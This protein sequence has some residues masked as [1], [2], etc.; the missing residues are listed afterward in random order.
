MTIWPSKTWG[1]NMGQLGID[2]A[3]DGL[4]AG[5]NMVPRTDGTIEDLSGNGN[6]GTINGPVFE[7]SEIGPGMKVKTAG[8]KITSA[9]NGAPSV[10]S[11][12]GWAK[13]LSTGSLGSGRIFDKGTNHLSLYTSGAVALTL[14]YNNGA[15]QNEV[16]NDSYTQNT[17]FFFAITYD[18]AYLKAF[19]DSEEIK[20]INDTNVVLDASNWILG[21]A[22]L[23]DRPMDG[24]ISN[25]QFFERALTP[26]E[27]E[28][29]YNAG[30]KA[31]NF[32]T[33]YG[34]TETVSADTSGELSNS[35]F[36]VESGSFHISNDTING[37]SAKVIECVTA[38][39][40]QIP[41]AYF[42]GGDTQAAYGSW[43]WWINKSIVGNTRA[44]MAFV[45]NQNTDPTDATF[46]GYDLRLETNESIRLARYDNGTPTFLQVTVADVVLVDTWYKLKVTRSSNGDF[47]TYIDGQ[48]V[49][50]TGG[51]GTNPITDSTYTESKYMIINLGAGDKIAYA[52]KNGDC[53]IVKYQGI[54]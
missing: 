38:G 48:L 49:D 18:G 11:V 42:F 54:V 23:L 27:I 3:Q 13:I 51:V 35:P 24:S 46:D 26:A 41:S 2:C 25:F 1:R 50:L 31:V 30:A 17:N 28:A 5:Y 22:D 47:T 39:V 16:L 36:R 34:V 52:T 9:Y 21:N 29:E 12:C 15:Q 37:C 8:N 7:F 14:R 33:D 45:A 44:Q 40:V 32:K 4:V 19:I 10:F 53:S 43:E 20:S 6:H